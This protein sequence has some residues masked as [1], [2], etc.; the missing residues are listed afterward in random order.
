MTYGQIIATIQCYIHIATDK[1]VDIA[2]PRNVGEIKKMQLMYE[3]A[4]NNLIYMYQV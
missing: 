3:V 4:K 2:M 1:N